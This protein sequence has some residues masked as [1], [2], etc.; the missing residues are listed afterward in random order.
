[1]GLDLGILK[2][3]GA[4]WSYG[5]T[6][7]GQG[8]ENARDFLTNNA[9]IRQAIEEQVRANSANYKPGAAAAAADE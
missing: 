8:R 1:M 4:F 3:S 6:R 9:E 2:K 5:D 7:L